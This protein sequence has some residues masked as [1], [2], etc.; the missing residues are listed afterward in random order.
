[1]GAPASFAESLRV[2]AHFTDYRSKTESHGRT[3]QSSSEGFQQQRPTVSSN[4][5]GSRVDEF[6]L[7][8]RA[9]EL[10]STGQH[11]PSED[12]LLEI[13]DLLA[14]G[15]YGSPFVLYVVAERVRQELLRRSDAVPLDESDFAV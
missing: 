7:T 8:Q 6:E 11:H 13:H 5:S 2:P 10:P 3:M 12:R 4:G 1:M 9:V 14:A 15:F